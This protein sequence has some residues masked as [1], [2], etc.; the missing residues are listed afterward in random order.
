MNI[1]LKAPHVNV[2]CDLSLSTSTA[3]PV[4]A[5]DFELAVVERCGGTGAQLL[6]EIGPIR[7]TLP[8]VYEVTD[9]LTYV[10]EAL[11]ALTTEEGHHW[12]CFIEEPGASYVA[13]WEMKWSGNDLSIRI[14]P[15]HESRRQDG[16]DA[17]EFRVSKAQ[18]VAEW[19][20]VLSRLLNAT[21]GVSLE[22]DD[23]RVRALAL[24]SRRHDP[25][26]RS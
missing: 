20:G 5:R 4:A 1:D 19:S 22:I 9:A 14:E 11:E 16:A 12:L 13:D 2:R 24:V 15:L 18:F 6:I 21:E 10:I 7:Q 8:L 23:E 3:S 25:G 17:G 26:R